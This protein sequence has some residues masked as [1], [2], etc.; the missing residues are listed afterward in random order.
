VGSRIKLW[1]TTIALSAT[2]LTACTSTTI[3]E[4]FYRPPTA[5]V[6][7]VALSPDADF[8]KYKSIQLTPLGVY[9]PDNVPQ[10]P[11][12]DLDRLR[13]YF[14]EAFLAEIGNDYRIVSTTGPEVLRVNAQ[15]IDLKIVGAGG[16]YEPSARLREVVA[17]GELTLVME[18]QD[19]ITERAL[20]RAADTTSTAN[21]AATSREADW[22]NVRQAA[23]RWAEMFRQ[24]LDMNLQGA[25]VPEASDAR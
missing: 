19:S 4:P 3:V 15:I 9:F 16:T 2:A 14:R 1:A 17:A 22:D 18:L 13:Q 25:R 6:E 8:S 11:A 24:F 23:E 20:V 12:A 7:Y 10:P 5:Q 21:P